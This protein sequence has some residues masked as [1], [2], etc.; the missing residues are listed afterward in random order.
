MDE[1]TMAKYEE[2]VKALLALG[3]S[4]KN[5]LEYTE[6][7][8]FMAELNL[9]QEQLDKVADSLERSGIDVLRIPADDDMELIDEDIL[10]NDEENVDIENIDLS[11][12]DG[13]STEDPVRMYL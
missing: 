11:V 13:V 6:I 7:T 2:K 4:K 1:N 10:L 9:T 8:D 12:P 5:M 3:K